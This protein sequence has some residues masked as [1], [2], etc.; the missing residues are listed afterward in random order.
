M[1]KS[2]VGVRVML[3]RARAQLAQ[4]WKEVQ[5]PAPAAHARGVSAGAAP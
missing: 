3:H 4:R 1:G 5:E 2:E